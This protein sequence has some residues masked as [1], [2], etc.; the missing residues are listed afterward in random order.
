MSESRSWQGLLFLVVFFFFF[1][2]GRGYLAQKVGVVKARVEC[3]IR[4]F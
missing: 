2:D 4:E 3:W 1:I